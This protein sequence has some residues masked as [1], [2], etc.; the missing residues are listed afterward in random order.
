MGGPTSRTR[1]Q[2]PRAEPPAPLSR[3]RILASISSWFRKLRQATIDHAHIPWVILVLQ[4]LNFWNEA[5]LSLR[6]R[7]QVFIGIDHAPNGFAASHLID[8][9][10]EICVFGFVLYRW[11]K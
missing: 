10:K 8:P 1:P 4:L 7:A 6:I 5:M 9:E 11:M 2:R 3:T